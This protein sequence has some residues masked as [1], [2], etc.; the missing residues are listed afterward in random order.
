MKNSF[1]FSFLIIIFNFMPFYNDISFNNVY[2][3]NCDSNELVCIKYHS[4]LKKCY[5]KLSKIWFVFDLM[6]SVRNSIPMNDDMFIGIICDL[7]DILKIIIENKN[8][9]KDL[10]IIH[11]NDRDE[12]NIILK[13]LIDNKIVVS[14]EIISKILLSIYAFLRNDDSDRFL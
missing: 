5:E 4:F 6:G 10:L 12:I 13:Y 11:N 9:I 8:E 3:I 14:H 1:V 7:A 2:E